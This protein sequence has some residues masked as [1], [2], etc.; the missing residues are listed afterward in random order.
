MHRGPAHLGRPGRLDTP[1]KVA[2]MATTKHSPA[3]RRDG[4]GQ[5]RLAG[6]R[7]SVQQD[8]LPGGQQAGEQLG[9]PSKGRRFGAMFGLITM[10]DKP[11]QSLVVLRG[12]EASILPPHGLAGHT[13][14]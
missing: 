1:W 8:A 14:L 13:P 11:I 6:A 2:V 9:V 4:L 12:L 5:Q 7:R 10:T 3:L